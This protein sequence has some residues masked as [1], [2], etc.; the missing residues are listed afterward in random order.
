[1]GLLALAHAHAPG[2]R[3]PYPFDVLGAQI[4]GMIGQLGDAEALLRGDAGTVVAV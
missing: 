4:Q 1:V 2:L 3:T